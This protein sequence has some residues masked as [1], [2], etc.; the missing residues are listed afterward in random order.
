M[1]TFIKDIFVKLEIFWDQTY[2]GFT[3]IVNDKFLSILLGS[4]ALRN[5]WTALLIINWKSFKHL[6]HIEEG[7]QNL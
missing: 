2:I 1:E 7:P 5:L 4:G 6:F 3:R